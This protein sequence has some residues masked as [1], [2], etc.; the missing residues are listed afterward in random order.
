MT[1]N[2]RG[3]CTL[4][5]DPHVPANS[6]RLKAVESI[7]QISREEEKNSI[8]LLLHNWPPFM[9]HYSFGIQLFDCAQ[10]LYPERLAD[11]ILVSL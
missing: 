11:H 2:H 5:L 7:S 4:I 6:C 1:I 9:H 8:E 3:H 10:D